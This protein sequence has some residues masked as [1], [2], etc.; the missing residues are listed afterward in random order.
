MRN[1]LFRKLMDNAGYEKGNDQGWT[2]VELTE[3]RTQAHCHKAVAP[4]ADYPLQSEA[5]GNGAN[6]P[7]VSKQCT[8]MRPSPWHP[9]KTIFLVVLLALFLVWVIVSYFLHRNYEL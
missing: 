9:L 8:P 6:P 1:E 5:N 7:C 2:T 4:E 3:V